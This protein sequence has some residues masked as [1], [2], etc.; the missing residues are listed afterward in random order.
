MLILAQRVQF[1]NNRLRN[2]CFDYHVPKKAL[3][4]ESTTKI[5]FATGDYAK[6]H[7]LFR[8]RRMSPIEVIDYIANHDLWKA[9]QVRK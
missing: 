4:H 5:N 3:Y 2:W 1:C 9:T 7:V 8:D 6:A